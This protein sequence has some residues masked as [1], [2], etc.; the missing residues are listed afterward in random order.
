LVELRQLAYLE[1]VLE[2][3]TFSAAAERAG[4]A[5]PA[6]WIQVRALEREWGVPLFEPAG[7]RV[8]PTAAALYLRDH[9]RA[10]LGH[11]DRLADAVRATRAG[12]AGPIRIPTA[13]YPGASAFIAEAIVEYARRHPGAPLPTRV[14]LGTTATVYEALERG[15]I[16]L[17]TGILPTGSR[18][19]SAPL[20]PVELVACG[21]GLPAGVLE[22]R[23]LVRHP[24]ATLTID[25]Q[26]RVLVEAILRTERLHARIVYEDVYPD[27]LV[28]LAEAGLAV[29]VLASDALPVRP[30]APVHILRHRGRSLGGTLS[31][32]WR[33]DAT[34]SAAAKGFRDVVV[35]L[36]SRVSL[37]GEPPARAIS[38]PRRQ[39]AARAR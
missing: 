38:R 7:R 5:Q 26:S 23:D 39:P 30:K 32:V 13:P 36:A 1:A 4:V 24:L 10:A 15:D 16:D 34:L 6:L 12:E 3:G 37:P 8:R 25:F 18:F 9:L 29:A 31:L 11:A 35:E 33:D 19:I 21:R 17:T 2:T 20:Y 27:S 14:P 28:R 22:V